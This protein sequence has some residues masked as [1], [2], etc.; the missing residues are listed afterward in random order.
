MWKLLC[1][2]SPLTQD[3]HSVAACINSSLPSTIFFWCSPNEIKKWGEKKKEG[4]NFGNNS[5][6]VIWGLLVYKPSTFD[7]VF[8]L[9]SEWRTSSL[10]SS[11]HRVPRNAGSRALWLFKARM[12]Y[13][14]RFHWLRMGA[15]LFPLMINQEGS[16]SSNFFFS[17]VKAVYPFS[18]FIRAP[19]VETRRHPQRAFQLTW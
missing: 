17:S 7:L 12:S 19:W 18:V 3:I 10:W 13:W 16:I 2:F 8:L 4:K 15:G 9:K 14:S 6:P 1:I 11:P 5:S